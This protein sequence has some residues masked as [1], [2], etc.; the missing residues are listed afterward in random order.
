MTPRPVYTSAQV[1][2]FMA[3]AR[4]GQDRQAAYL[5]AAMERHPAGKRRT[6]QIAPPATRTP[7]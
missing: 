2:A 6:R 3:E 5:A 7:P 1:A 4:G